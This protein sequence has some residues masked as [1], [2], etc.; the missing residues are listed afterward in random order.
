[1][2]LQTII[3]NSIA[4]ARNERMKTS[5]QLTIGEMLLKLESIQDKYKDE[6]EDI[7]VFFDF[8]YLHPAG[9]ISWRGSYAELA[10]EFTEES[11]IPIPKLHDFIKDLRECIGKE[12]TGYKGGEYTM[13]KNTPVW[14]ANYGNS[15]KTG[16]V[17]VI[18]DGY[19]VMIITDFCEL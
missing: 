16:V 19:D 15:G 4:S 17:D 2:D 9:F 12:F 14:V 1:M 18:Y 7:N 8:A 13:G 5:E 3:D 10:I 11:D 6:K